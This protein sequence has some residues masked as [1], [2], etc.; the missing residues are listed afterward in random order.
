MEGLCGVMLSR[1]CRFKAGSPPWGPPAEGKGTAGWPGPPE[2]QGCCPRLPPQSSA[3]SSRRPFGRSLGCRG[4]GGTR[5]CQGLGNKNKCLI[6]IFCVDGY[7]LK[8]K[9]KKQKAGQFE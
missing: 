6:C 9:V 5:S 3:Q 1:G 7:L 4:S 8:A 2:G